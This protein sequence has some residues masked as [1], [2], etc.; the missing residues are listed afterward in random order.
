VRSAGS[1]ATEVTDPE[2]GWACAVI[3]ALMSIVLRAEDDRQERKDA[4]DCFEQTLVPAAVLDADT[5]HHANQAWR[6]SLGSAIPDWARTSLELVLRTGATI[7]L[8]EVITLI[9]NRTRWLTATL[10]RAGT[11]HR[12]AIVV[13]KEM[14]DSAIARY[15]DVTTEIAVWSGAIN[16][17][18][19]CDYCNEQTRSYAGD[20][21]LPVWQQALHPDDQMRWMYAFA[22]TCQQRRPTTLEVRLRRTDG[23]FRWHSV[24]VV[25]SRSTPRWFSVAV[26]CHQD[27]LR[28]V[29]RGELLDRLR[30]ARIDA[31]RAHQLKDQIL[32]AVSHELRAPVTTLMLWERVLR[33]PVADPAARLQALDAIHQSASAQSR[34]VADLLDV[35]RGISGKLYVDIRS[36][37][38]GRIVGEATEAALPAALAKRI[39]LMNDQSTFDGEIAGDASRLRQVLDNL[40]S[41]AIKFTDPGGRVIVSLRR[42]GR[43]IVIRVS[44]TGCGIAPSELET[45]FEPFSQGNDPLARRHGGLG[46]GLAIA[47]QIIELHNGTITAFSEGPSR[48]AR[49]TLT[50]PVAGQPRAPSPPAG[51]APP[52]ALRSV[53]VLVIDDDERVRNALALLLDRAGAIVDRADSA[54][55]ARQQLV[56]TNPH[57]VICDIAMPD[58]DGYT[59]IRSLR[60]SGNKVPA[61]ALTAYASSAHSDEALSAGFDLHVAKPVDFQNLVASLARVLDLRRKDAT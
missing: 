29:E 7:H 37:D 36:I 10:I 9:G 11:D 17:P 8:P 60:A 49:M 15:L 25:A 33:D 39:S 38:I 27:R 3:D 57:I 61:I 45:I 2:L 31:E 43:V 34:I 21:F 51:I 30:Q 14:T 46:L 23:E 50:L 47:K 42:T 13:W 20:T 5:V 32:A 40:L 24:S 35:S 52:R 16:A 19:I 53:R 1:A 56:R 59:F 28:D 4:L 41:N 48:G 6:R 22:Q 44:D 55:A 12:L 54:A 18:S 26:D 58:E